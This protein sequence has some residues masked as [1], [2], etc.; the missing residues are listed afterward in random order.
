MNPLLAGLQHHME[1]TQ[2]LVVVDARYTVPEHDGMSV[3]ECALRHSSV[4]DRELQ[5]AFQ[6]CEEQ[7]ASLG[8]PWSKTVSVVV[9]TTGETIVKE[10]NESSLLLP[11]VVQPGHSNGAHGNGFNRAEARAKGQRFFSL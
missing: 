6:E 1:V 10:S 11:T 3:L 2:P 7:M 5:D 4:I 8:A 9:E